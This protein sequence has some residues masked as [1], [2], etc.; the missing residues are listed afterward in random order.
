MVSVNK[1]SELA[2]N[3]KTQKRQFLEEGNVRWTVRSQNG[4]REQ[5]SRFGSTDRGSRR[6]SL[7]VQNV[8]VD[9]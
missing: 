1:V 8:S 5:F 9:F 2:A 3:Q 4:G 7:T 6:S